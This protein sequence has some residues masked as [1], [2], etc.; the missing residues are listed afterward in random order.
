MVMSS[1]VQAI[2]DDIVPRLCQI[3]GVT[4]IVLGGYAGAGNPYVCLGC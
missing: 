4:G 1:N 2:I 3:D